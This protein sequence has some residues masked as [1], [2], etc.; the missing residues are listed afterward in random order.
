MAATL[1]QTT[2]FHTLSWWP[3]RHLRPSSAIAKEP[4]LMEVGLPLLCSVHTPLNPSTA[5]LSVQIIGP[6]TELVPLSLSLVLSLVQKLKAQQESV[7]ELV[8]L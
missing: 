3:S 7:L 1:T 6:V 5:F 4:V 2:A 8:D